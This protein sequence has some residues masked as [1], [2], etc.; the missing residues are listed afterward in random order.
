MSAHFRS[1]GWALSGAFWLTVLG[2]ATGSQATGSQATGAQPSDP[3]PETIPTPAAES[4]SAAKPQGDRLPQPLINTPSYGGAQTA[5][6]AYRY[7]EQQRREALARQLSLN[8]QLSSHHWHEA[9]PSSYYQHY[10]VGSPV[11]YA[12]GGPRWELRAYRAAGV[13]APWI[14]YGIGAPH[15]VDRVPQPLGYVKTWLGPNSYNYR[16]LYGPPA[17]ANPSAVSSSSAPADVPG[18]VGLVPPPPKPEFLTPSTGSPQVRPARWPAAEPETVP[19]P[20][21]QS[22][23]PQEF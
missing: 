2:A 19:A 20:P 22:A 5:G 10:W 7:A 12:Y 17:G 3:S 9:Y 15:Y 11:N 18:T 8:D 16:P 13:L 14:A 23:G 4:S 21:P 6:D 1:A